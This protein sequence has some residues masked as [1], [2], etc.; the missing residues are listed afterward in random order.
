MKYASEPCGM[1][2]NPSGG[3]GTRPGGCRRG[4]D[5]TAVW[6]AG[7]AASPQAPTNFNQRA[8]RAGGSEARQIILLRKGFSQRGFSHHLINV[9][10][11]QRLCNIHKRARRAGE[12]GGTPG[13]PA[14][15]YFSLSP[16]SLLSNSPLSSLLSPLSCLS[17]LRSLLSSFFSLLSL[18]PSRLSPTSKAAASGAGAHRGP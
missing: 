13:T 5:S 2:R 4:H 3:F 6:G 8:S 1:L 17:S 10:R 16:L 11:V 18:L 15:V 12:G 9:V 14:C 7:P